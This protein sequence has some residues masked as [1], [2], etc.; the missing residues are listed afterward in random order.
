MRREVLSVAE[1]IKKEGVAVILITHYMEE[2]VKADKIYVMNEGKIVISGTPEE[3][4]SQKEEIK[5]GLK[6]SF[7]KI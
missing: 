4:F 2:A 1:K 5:K 3:V 7:L 6:P